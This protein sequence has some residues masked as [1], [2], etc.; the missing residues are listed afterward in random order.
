M[1]IVFTLPR[2]YAP[3][4]F[5]EYSILSCHGRT[6]WVKNAPLERLRADL[7]HINA[8]IH[9]KAGH[10]NLRG[11]HRLMSTSSLH[12]A[13]EMND[14]STMSTFNRAAG[15][16]GEAGWF[17]RDSEVTVAP[18]GACIPGAHSSFSERVHNYRAS[19]GHSRC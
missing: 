13:R 9:L 4:L 5:A 19:Q 6:S 16:G 2:F 7:N 14:S 3:R 17:L 1:F 8:M 10:G 12:E 11:Y 15:L 18:Q